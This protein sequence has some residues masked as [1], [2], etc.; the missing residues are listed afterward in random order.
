MLVSDAM[1]RAVVTI[2]PDETIEAAAE[3][4]RATGAE[5]LLVCDEQTLV[6]IICTC[7]LRTAAPGD[8]VSDCMSLPVVTV[9]PDTSLEDVALTMEE[10]A[11][12]CIPVAV[13]GLI[14]GIVSDDELV[15]CGIG[16]RHPHR[17]C[18]ARGRRGPRR[19]AP[20]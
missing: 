10:C 7:D 18:H 16:A 14:L 11:V 19:A 17:H 13:G 3:I 20:N 5:H 9:R 6:G 1:N 8:T 12:G 4:A 15:R 2:E